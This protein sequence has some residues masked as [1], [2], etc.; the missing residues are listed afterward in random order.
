[1]KLIFSSPYY[2]RNIVTG[3][4]KRF[5]RI[6]YELQDNTDIGIVV[7]QGQVPNELNSLVSLYEIPLW[8]ASSRVIT[9]FYLNFLYSFFSLKGYAVISDF[10]PLPISMFFSK[11][12]FQLIFDVRIIDHFGRWSRFSAFFMKMQWRFSKKKIVISE[13]T[14][15]RL[16]EGLSAKKQEIIVSYCGVHSSEIFKETEPAK[17]KIVDLLYIATFEDRKNHINLIKALS[18]IKKPLSVLFLG[19]D[20]GTKAFIE[21]EASR[22]SQHSIRFIDHVTDYELQQL[23]SSSKVFISPSLYEGFGMPI[24]EAYSRGCKV[25]CSDIFVFREVLSNKASYFQPEKVSSI[26]KAIKKAVNEEYKNEK[27]EVESKFYWRT[28]ALD[29]KKNIHKTIVQKT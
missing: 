12:Q 3:A 23:Y 20:L 22:I 16:I 10:N 8:I 17:K 14:K 4:N 26:S 9:F 18:S 7:V 28:I 21:D 15:S 2:K 6:I 1:M 25:V 29:L 24:L 11:K 13:F 27:I 19:R 5:D